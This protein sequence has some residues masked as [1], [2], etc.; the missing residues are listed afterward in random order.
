MGGLRHADLDLYGQLCRQERLEVHAQAHAATDARELR[1]ERRS[2]PR[3]E[4]ANVG[5]K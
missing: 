1:R 5:E 3:E 4:E 2:V